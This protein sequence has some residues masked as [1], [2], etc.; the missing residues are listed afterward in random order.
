VIMGKFTNKC[1]KVPG[2]T[3]AVRA[4]PLTFLQ[5]HRIMTVVF[6]AFQSLPPGRS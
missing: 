2:M 1:G 5:I 4:I 6:Q 3:V